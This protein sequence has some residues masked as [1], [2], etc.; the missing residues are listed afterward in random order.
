M[1]TR[2]QAAKATTTEIKARLREIKAQIASL[3]KVQ[4]SS[5]NSYKSEHGRMRAD[6]ITIMGWERG[7]LNKELATR[8][9]SRDAL[10]VAA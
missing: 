1:M 4:E 8:T 9:T 6:S 5:A 2:D 3:T 7:W 10:P